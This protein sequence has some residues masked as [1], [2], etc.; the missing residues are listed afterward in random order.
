MRCI[1]NSALRGLL[2]GV[3]GFIAFDKIIYTARLPDFSYEFFKIIID[4]AIG[5]LA[6]LVLV[7]SVD[8]AVASYSGP[9]RWW[10]YLGGALGGA[11]ALSLG[12]VIYSNL[13]YLGP[14]TFMAEIGRA[15][16]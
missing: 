6:G 4:T 7:F 9:R 15:H 10:A 11:L 1:R 3:V 8:L 2:G 14:A 13:I 12:L 5:A 16:V